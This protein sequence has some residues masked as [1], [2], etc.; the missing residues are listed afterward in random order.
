MLSGIHT[1]TDGECI[2]IHNLQDIT[3]RDVLVMFVFSRFYKIDLSYIRMAKERGT[4][5][6]LIVNEMTSPLTPDAVWVL[7]VPGANSSLYHSTI[8]ADLIAE[9]ILNRSSTK[10]D[11]RERI[12]E[13]DAITS[14]QRL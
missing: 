10:A 8:A 4:K 12:D 3:D 9:Y 11:F 1:L 7:L 6:A 2:S 14:D 13:Q 5:V